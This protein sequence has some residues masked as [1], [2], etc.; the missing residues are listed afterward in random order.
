KKKA[1]GVGDYWTH[2]GTS[3]RKMV[4]MTGIK[5]H[6]RYTHLFFSQVKMKRKAVVF[7]CNVSCMKTVA[8]SA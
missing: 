6:A 8:G 2:Y 5:Q 4:R 7:W 3:P 1:G